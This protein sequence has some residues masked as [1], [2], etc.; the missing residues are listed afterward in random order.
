MARHA[1]VGIERELFSRLASRYRRRWRTDF[2]AVDVAGRVALGDRRGERQCPAGVEVCRLAVQESL[3][4]GEPIVMPGPGETLLW[5]VPL[6]RNGCLLGGL[7]ATIAERKLFR[8]GSNEASVDVRA[9]CADLLRMAVEHN[10]TNAALLETRLGENQ[11]ESIR[12]QSIHTYKASP[13]YDVRTMYLLEEPA[14]IAAIRRGDRGEARSILNRLLVGMIHR[15]GSRLELSKSFFMELVAMMS[16]TA[17]EAGGAPEE[18]LG[19]NYDSVSRLAAIHSDEEL[20]R[21]LREMLER[22][23]DAI[24]R[25]PAGVQAV[26]LGH[27][28]RF[29][30]EH[31][32]EG[33]SR[34]DAAKAAAM[35]P[36]HFSR[37]FRKH[38]GQTFTGLLNHLRTDRAADLLLRSDKPL[39]LIS[40]E[41]GFA[42]QSHLTK[43]FRRRFKA[44]PA[45]YRS[46]H[47]ITKP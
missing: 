17:V 47:Q 45:A 5:A 37:Q 22:I 21:W 20:A 44:T 31:C 8:R 29:M 23:M 42:D 9:A 36:A 14:L 43:V 32:G 46:E 13:H 1:A 19:T 18:L 35:S 40:L 24:Q 12:A 6:M 38:F 4:W 10:L 39:K 26:Q 7:V 2:H 11:R 16:R 30:S 3:R 34:D 33:I 41:C 25:S 15:A 28:L 27:V